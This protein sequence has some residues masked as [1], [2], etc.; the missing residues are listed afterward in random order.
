MFCIM[1]VS[2]DTTVMIRAYDELNVMYSALVSP[3]AMDMPSRA[4]VVAMLIAESISVLY[5][6]KNGC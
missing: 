2:D 1:S 3:F 5:L 6:R 4:I